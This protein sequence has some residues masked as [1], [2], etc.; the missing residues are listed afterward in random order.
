MVKA[1]VKEPVTLRNFCSALHLYFTAAVCQRWWI[2]LAQR[3]EVW[4]IASN[5]QNETGNF[6]PLFCRHWKTQPW[7][8]LNSFCDRQLQDIL[9]SCFEITWWSMK[10][11]ENSVGSQRGTS[12]QCSIRKEGFYQLSEVEYLRCD[13]TWQ[14]RIWSKMR[15]APLTE[16]ALSARCSQC[17]QPREYSHVHNHMSWNLICQTPH[18]LEK[19]QKHLFCFCQK[20]LHVLK[21]RTFRE[22]NAWKVMSRIK[23]GDSVPLKL[24]IDNVRCNRHNWLIIEANPDTCIS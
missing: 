21:P 9:L 19:I 8:W 10:R 18:N 23:C 1:G 3:H 20:Y 22:K 5:L 2:G 15:G 14:I 17:N 12:S 4:G 16:D 24:R 6:S 11:K 13:Q 7:F